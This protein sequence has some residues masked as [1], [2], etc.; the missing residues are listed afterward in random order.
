MKLNAQ[1]VDLSTTALE[2]ARSHRKT[3]IYAA[4]VAEV[5]KLPKGKGL[6][7]SDEFPKSM[8]YSLEKYGEKNDFPIS[9]RLTK[10][11]HKFVVCAKTGEV[12][13]ESTPPKKKK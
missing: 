12:P 5:K 4:I 11:T 7:L 8:R 1:T 6:L 2:Q 13:V 9:V 3:A 10:D